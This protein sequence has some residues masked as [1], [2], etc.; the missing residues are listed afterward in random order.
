MFSK[1]IRIAS[2]TLHCNKTSTWLWICLISSCASWRWL[3]VRTR[4]RNAPIPDNMSGVKCGWYQWTNLRFIKLSTSNF[5]RTKCCCCFGGMKQESYTTNDSCILHLQGS[6]NGRKI[7]TLCEDVT[8]LFEDISPNPRTWPRQ[9][10]KSERL[11]KYVRSLC[12]PY[13]LCAIDSHDR[14]AMRQV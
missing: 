12:K 14:Q 13:G 4:K 3:T 11:L 1:K 7:I 2:L 10:R 8:E 5:A 9:A 6:R